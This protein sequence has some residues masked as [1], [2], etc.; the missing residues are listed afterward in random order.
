[1]TLHQALADGLDEVLDVLLGLLGIALGQG[2]DGFQG[3]IRVDR[4]G[5]VAAE[6]REVVG[7]RG[8]NRFRRPGR[9]WCAGPS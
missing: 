6:Q 3:Q 9:C 4:F 8:P 2:F 7:L 5:T 1:M